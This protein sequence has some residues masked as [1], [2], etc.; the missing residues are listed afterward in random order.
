M[1]RRLR[2][3]IAREENANSNSA[4]HQQETGGIKV[5]STLDDAANKTGTRFVSSNIGNKDSAM[6]LD[7]RIK[8]QETMQDHYADNQAV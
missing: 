8:K 1:E 7:Y 2:S 6:N 5:I 4:L 3:T